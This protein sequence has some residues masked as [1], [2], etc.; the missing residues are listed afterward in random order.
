MAESQTGHKVKCLKT[1]NGL[2]F[3]NKTFN[4]F[5]NEHGIKRHLTIPSTPQQNGTAERMN[6]TLLEKARCM[7]ISAG[8]KNSLWGEAVITASYLINRSPSSVIGF[9]TPQELWTGKK[10][11]IKHLRPFCCTAY[12][13]ISQGKLQPR[14][15]KC[16]MLGYPEG[17]K[18]YK[19]L[20]IQPRGYK[21]ITSRSV[22]FNEKEFHF[23]TILTPAIE[24]S[25]TLEETSNTTAQNGQFYEANQN[26][27]ENEEEEFDIG[28]SS[29]GFS[30]STENNTTQTQ[31]ESEQT[32]NDNA[33]RQPHQLG[34]GVSNSDL[35]NSNPAD[36]EFSLNDAESG[37]NDT[38]EQ[39][40]TV[41]NDNDLVDYQLVRDREPRI[42]LPNTRF[43][44]FVNLH[45]SYENLYQNYSKIVEFAFLVSDVVRNFVPETY[46]QA[47]KSINANDWMKAMHEEIQS[48][49]ANNT[50]TLV[51]KHEKVRLID[52]KWIYKIKEGADIHEP[53]RYKARL[54][55][56]GFTQK[57][58]VDYNEIFSPVVKYK[59][60]R[61]LLAMTAVFNWEL[62][63]M[64]VKTAFLHGDLNETI[65][66]RQPKGFIDKEKAEHACLLKKSIYELKQSPRQWNKKFDACMLKMNFTRSQYD[67]CLYFKDVK[68]KAP[69]YVLLYV[70]DILLISSSKVSINGVKH[71]LKRHFDMKDLGPAQ[72]ILG[73]KILRDRAKRTIYLSQT[74][75]L[76]KVLNRFAME[77]AKP[78]PIP[79][80][81]HLDFSKKDCPVST[82]DKKKMENVPYDVAVG[83]IMYAML[84]TRPDLAFAISVLSRY[85]SNPG[86][87]H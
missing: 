30:G 82:L 85:M 69:L 33:G 54:V 71:D 31:E 25:G 3:C 14:A 79:L 50:W 45:E 9:R 44:D 7:L 87:K 60:M 64:D 59:T 16:V 19:L 4:E 81:G 55:A 35:S 29:P 80:G 62:E 11:S 83:S 21:V 34:G 52:C 78:A 51:P 12:A 23:K 36:D 86:E 17:I 84:C 5:C 65:H 66:M 49:H 58:G 6:K 68:S 56:K 18:G 75:Y 13:Q 77:N 1:D 57:E 73:V 53:P 20:L 38:I 47:V 32:T 46:E 63:Q 24:N 61:L 22:T 72:K 42:R 2:E 67:T 40:A 8:M 76:H 10:P 43:A 39:N 27:P 37:N 70:D 74:D 48:M 15:Q 41:L 26:I 28:Y